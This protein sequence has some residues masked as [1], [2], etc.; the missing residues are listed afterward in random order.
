MLNLMRMLMVHWSPLDHLI[1][2][3]WL[4]RSA[5]ERTRRSTVLA[6]NQHPVNYARAEWKQ[7]M[8]RAPRPGRPAG[9]RVTVSLDEGLQTSSLLTHMVA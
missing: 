2:C 3:S 5:A 4:Q 8:A 6:D 9:R 1:Y 7:T